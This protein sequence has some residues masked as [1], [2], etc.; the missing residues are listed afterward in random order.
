MLTELKRRN[1]LRVTFAYLV[2]GWLLTEVLTTVLP[3]LDAPAWMSRAV[4]LMFALG[5][6]PAV[7]LSWSFRLTPQGIKRQSD[8]DDD[9]E[10]LALLIHGGRDGQDPVG[11]SEDLLR[12]FGDRRALDLS[13]LVELQGFKGI[14]EVRAAR[15]KVAFE[16]GRRLLLHPL[17]RAGGT[18]AAMLWNLLSLRW[19]LWV[20]LERPPFHAHVVFRL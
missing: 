8:T 11:M 1:V 3:T 6:I 5:F 4:I 10:L 15:L 19:N 12:R 17:G 14:G 2:V 13:S 16:L 20:K 7:A 18:G 9:A